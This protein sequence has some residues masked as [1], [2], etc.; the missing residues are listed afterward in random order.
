MVRLI[1]EVRPTHVGLENVPE[2]RSSLSRQHLI[3]ALNQTGYTISERLLC[4]TE[5]GSLNR[6][7]RYYLLASQ[8]ALP[9][10]EATTT[11]TRVLPELEDN[12]DWT[13]YRLPN[14]IANQYESAIHCVEAEAW[15]AGQSQTACFTAAYG[16]SPVFSGSFLKHGNQIRR[17][18]PREILWQLGF[19]KTYQIPD[20][21]PE[22][23]WPLIGNSLS[24]HAVNYLL[25]HL[26]LG[27]S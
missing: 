27:A 18:T 11:A 13:V 3:E 7:K 12:I 1:V 5:L 26:P 15:L 22:R 21:P 20:W 2:F 8:H 6:R 10:W 9:D 16:R 25:R 17:F 19:P 4:P 24:L 14:Q 23:L